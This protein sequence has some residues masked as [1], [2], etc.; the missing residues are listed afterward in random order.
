MS[1]KATAFH[2]LN[3]RYPS[4]E[5]KIPDVCEHFSVRCTNLFQMMRELDFKV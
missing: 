3:P 4:K 5:A 2:N 1:S